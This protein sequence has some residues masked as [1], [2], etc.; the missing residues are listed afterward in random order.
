VDGE[1]YLGG[2]NALLQWQE[3]ERGAEITQ[4][5]K[6]DPRVLA[7]G[8]RGLQAAGVTPEQRLWLL[9]NSNFEFPKLVWYD[10]DGALREHVDL[11]YSPAWLAAVDQDS[12]IVI[13]GLLQGEG[14]EC[15][16]LARESR[17]PL[18]RLP[19]GEDGF[20][21]NGAALVPGRLYVTSLEGVLYAIGERQDN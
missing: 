17:E 14:A 18:W 20:I 2:A 8:F 15:R 10:L 9:F 12:N 1:I 6:F 5:A 13:C 4:R 16:A 11:P 21:V 3:T 7:L 19:L